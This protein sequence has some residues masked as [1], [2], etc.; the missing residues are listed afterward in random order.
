[1]SLRAASALAVVW[2]VLAGSA[3]HFVV[4]SRTSSLLLASFVV[5][6]TVWTFRP[7]RMPVFRDGITGQYG[8]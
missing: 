2:V 6:Q 8:V 3:L 5:A 4:S 1:M 7:P